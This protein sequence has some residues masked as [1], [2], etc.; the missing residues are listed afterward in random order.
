METFLDSMKFEILIGKYFGILFFPR[1]VSEEMTSCDYIYC[2]PLIGIFS[3]LVMSNFMQ[4]HTRVILV[5]FIMQLLEITFFFVI[6]SSQITLLIYF[7]KNRLKIKKILLTI[8]EYS[9]KY[10][11]SKKQRKST[12]VNVSFG[13]MSFF[14]MCNLVINLM[15]NY[16]SYFITYN[17]ALVALTF[18]Q[19]WISKITWE[20]KLYLNNL[21]NFLLKLQND[22]EITKEIFTLNKKYAAYKEILNL[23]KN[24]NIVFGLPVFI[25]IFVIFITITGS[26]SYLV[27][28]LRHIFYYHNGLYE[29]CLLIIIL[30]IEFYLIINFWSSVTKEVRCFFLLYY[31]VFV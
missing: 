30:T 4:V 21:N 26:V 9:C 13:I 11:I 31:F 10:N 24:V 14:T 27:Y 12:K 20:C 29:S 3:A 17:I 22:N 28:F 7:L 23:I 19:Y 6:V 1:N 25:C 8:D 16:I 5:T 2:L 18:Q 15:D